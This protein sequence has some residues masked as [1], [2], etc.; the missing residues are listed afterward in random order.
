MKLKNLMLLCLLQSI[1]FM[2]A[3]GC[4]GNELIVKTPEFMDLVYDDVYAG[5]FFAST[6][7]TWVLN[8]N[9]PYDFFEN[10]GT[11]ECDITSCSLYEF[12]TVTDTCTSTALTMPTE[13]TF[14]SSFNLILSSLDSSTKPNI[15]LCID[16][17]NAV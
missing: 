11:T 15:K 6:S 8:P 13:L 9:G 5:H 10:T 2:V 3:W 4:V 16:C 17:G 1:C 14:D 7:R 12:D